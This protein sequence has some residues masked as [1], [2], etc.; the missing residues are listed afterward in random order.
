MQATIVHI[1]MVTLNLSILLRQVYSYAMEIG[2]DAIIFQIFQTFF[3]PVSLFVEFILLEFRK[4]ILIW[5]KFLP[6]S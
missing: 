4:D 6:P 5:L 2:R 3:F 1:Y